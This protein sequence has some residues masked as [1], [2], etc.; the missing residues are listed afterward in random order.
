MDPSAFRLDDGKNDWNIF[1]A[2]F[3]L[4]VLIVSVWSIWMI[5]GGFP[6]S[7]PIFD[8]I[9]M[10]FAAMRIV[11][12]VVYDSITGFFREYFMEVRITD[13]SGKRLVEVVPAKR[14][15]RG[16]L[17]DLVRCP[18][19]IGMWAGLIVTFCYFVFPWAWY[20]ILFLAVSGAASSLQVLM[21][22]I[23]WEAEDYKLDTWSKE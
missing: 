9:L 17:Y 11:R 7:V 3:F 18:W 2:V 6:V 14:G 19:C 16:T 5:R 22:L 21:N 15:A 12:L 4:A 13:V 8:A 23:G 20:V 10:A 1:F